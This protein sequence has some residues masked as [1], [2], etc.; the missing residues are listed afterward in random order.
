MTVIVETSNIVFSLV[1]AIEMILKIVANGLCAYVS[2]GFNV[3]DGVIVVLRY[4]QVIT[5]YVQYNSEQYR[6]RL[7]INGKI[8]GTVLSNW[9]NHPLAATR[10]ILV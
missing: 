3:F 6:F 1:F 7:K 9:G 10:L 5:K 8:F 4:V 2:N